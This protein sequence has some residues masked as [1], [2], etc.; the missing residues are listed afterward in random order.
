MLKKLI[1]VAIFVLIS[2]FLFAKTEYVYSAEEFQEALNDKEVEKIVLK[3]DITG[4]FEC[5]RGNVE[6]D[7]NGK[8]IRSDDWR[9][10]I[11]FF[12]GPNFDR[13]K[14]LKIKNLTFK[15]VEPLSEDFLGYTNNAQYYPAL[16]IENY[17]MIG[18][19]NVKFLDSFTG[20][21]LD[22]CFNTE[23]D[24]CEFDSSVFSIYL[25]QGMTHYGGALSI[26]QSAFRNF[27]NAIY[28]YSIAD[29]EKD[30]GIVEIENCQFYE[31][32]DYWMTIVKKE[33]SDNGWGNKKG[34]IHDYHFNFKNCYFD[35]ELIPF[36]SKYHDDSDIPSLIIEIYDL[37]GSMDDKMEEM[38]EL[39]NSALG[40]NYDDSEININA[41]ISAYINNPT[42]EDLNAFLLNVFKLINL[43][44]SNLYFENYFLDEDY[45]AQY[46]NDPIY[47]LCSSEK[48]LDKFITPMVFIGSANSKN[49]LDFV[50]QMQ[51]CYI[52]GE[53][54]NTLLSDIPAKKSEFFRNN[55]T[56]YNDFY[57]RRT[58]ALK[59][60]D[61]I[62][63]KAKQL[64][65]FYTTEEYNRIEKFRNL[66]IEYYNLYDKYLKAQ[67]FDVPLNYLYLSFMNQIFYNLDNRDKLERIA[68]QFTDF[69]VIKYNCS[70]LYV[71][72]DNF[73]QIL[74]MFKD[75]LGK[76]E[77]EEIQ[78]KA[79]T[80]PQWFKNSA[81]KLLK[82]LD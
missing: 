57:N 58:M 51:N 16:Y 33:D 71:T 31:S 56:L 40:Y 25:T 12:N 44:K 38:E 5:G 55:I 6:I 8:T 26:K 69:G 41:E 49:L 60:L 74:E 27:N 66:F 15:G 13:H 34:M 19:V 73:D 3:A 61:A 65:T 30:Q 9:N 11:I 53:S 78:A 29:S 2:T 42:K 37:A 76:K 17:N 48:I 21:T 24:S 22:G 18:L 46:G 63:N 80:T 36:A 54:L 43:K 77:Y 47:D 59:A 32:E 1:F 50:K 28:D 81:V 67:L 39:L 70:V 68:M 23:I 82:E 64:P 75:Y 52:E 10:E 35:K 45:Q 20:L 62:I 79:K 7:G 4:N 72:S 14:N